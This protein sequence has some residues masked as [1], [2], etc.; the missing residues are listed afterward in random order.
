LFTDLGLQSLIGVEIALKQTVMQIDISQLQSFEITFLAVLINDVFEEGAELLRVINE[1]LQQLF[2]FNR[3]LGDSVSSRESR[4]LRSGNQDD[5]LR[6][7]LN[8]LDD[9]CGLRVAS[10]LHSRLNVLLEV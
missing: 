1:D 3:L 5:I 8:L 9:S 10:V 4:L 6:N 2:D 7:L